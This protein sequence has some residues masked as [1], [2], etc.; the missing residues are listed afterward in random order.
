MNE[1]KVYCCNIVNI[2]YAKIVLLNNIDIYIYI[3]A[4]MYVQ[5]NSK[6]EVEIKSAS[7]IISQAQQIEK[8]LVS[9]KLEECLGPDVVASLS[10]PQGTMLKYGI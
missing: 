8:Q 6:D 5:E 4:N 1:L 3:Y 9:L 7:E 2:R 10:D